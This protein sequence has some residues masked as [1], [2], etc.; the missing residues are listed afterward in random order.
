MN[1]FTRG[2]W[3]ILIG[4]WLALIWLGVAIVLM[5]TFIGWPLAYKMFN[6]TYTILTGDF[7]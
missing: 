3:T 7:D 5:F 6:S 1:S 4:W 2:L